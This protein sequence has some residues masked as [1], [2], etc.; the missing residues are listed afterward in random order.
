MV[1]S[2]AKNFI[3]LFCQTFAL[4]IQ[5]TAL[6]LWGSSSSFPLLTPTN[7]WLGISSVCRYLYT[8]FSSN[9]LP[10]YWH[11][12]PDIQNRCVSMLARLF[13]IPS[14]ED[15]TQAMGTSTIGSSEGIM[16]AYSNT[17][18]ALLP[19]YW[20]NKARSSRHEK[21]LAEST[22]GCRQVFRQAK[23][24]YE[25]RRS[26]LLGESSS[27]LRRWGEGAYKTVDEKSTK[28][29]WGEHQQL[30]NQLW[31]IVCV[32]H[33]RSLCHRPQGVRRPGWRKHNRYLCN[34]R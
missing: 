15:G 22:Q 29:P 31:K 23:Y 25:L 7:L 24:R 20:C 17:N 16:Y 13:N 21:A 3:G 6:R 33:A 2:F 10:S 14:H 4:L 18:L 11:V 1:E 32:L 12:A 9:M 19:L 26:G 28:L 30:A 27:L 34:H 8:S 5:L